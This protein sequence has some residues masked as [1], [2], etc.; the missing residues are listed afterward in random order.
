MPLCFH[1][2]ACVP[3]RR[4]LDSNTIYLMSFLTIYCEL[5]AD[6]VGG[7]VSMQWQGQRLGPKQIF[8]QVK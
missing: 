3:S 7:F 2:N 5:L 4:L 1:S 8:A 6:R